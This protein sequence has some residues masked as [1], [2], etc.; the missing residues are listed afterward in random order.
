MPA[1]RW[2][3]LA[4][5]ALVTVS[6]YL[7]FVEVP[8]ERQMGVVQRI[9]YV[10]APAAWAAY[11]CFFVVA[12]ASIGYLWRGSERA[13]RVALAAAEVGVLMCTLNL[14]TGPIWARPIWGVWWTW[15]PRLTMTV[16]LWAI[17]VGYVMMRA[18]GRDDDA[19][20]SFAAVLGIVGVIAIP[21][22]R[23]SVRMLEGMHPAVTTTREGGTGLVDPTM[24]LTLY[25]SGVAMV[26]LALWLV[27]L[28]AR[29]EGLQRSAALLRRDLE[30][31]LE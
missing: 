9:L 20:A 5:T 15:D 23:V 26:L 31:G 30:Y 11:V 2:L 17:Y 4:A 28:R 25:L 18:F 3:G 21:V 19:I 13:D 8:T 22:I 12:G 14:V 1:M 24:R 6:L 7:I 16:I 10:H 29:V 27:A